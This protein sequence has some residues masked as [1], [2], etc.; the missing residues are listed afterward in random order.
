MYICAR[1]DYK[2]T[3]QTSV[4]THIQSKHEGLR[5]SCDWCDYKATTKGNLTVYIQSMHIGIMHKC[6]NV[7]MKLHTKL[8]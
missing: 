8:I 3:Q 4:T 5:Y 7:I 2:F 1:C 6:V